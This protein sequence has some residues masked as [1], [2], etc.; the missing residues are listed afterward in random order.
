MSDDDLRTLVSEAG[1]DDMT[2]INFMSFEAILDNLCNEYFETYD[3]DDDDDDD[4]GDEDGAE[5]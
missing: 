2:K 1:V 5:A 3:G 4:D